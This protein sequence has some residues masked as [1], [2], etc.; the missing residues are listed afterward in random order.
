MCSWVGKSGA[1]ADL[2]FVCDGDAAPR[3]PCVNLGAFPSQVVIEVI[4]TIQRAYTFARSDNVGVFP[5]SSI[6]EVIA[7]DPATTFDDDSFL[8]DSRCIIPQAFSWSPDV[9]YRGAAKV[10]IIV[11]MG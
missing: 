7:T 2:C 10:P 1:T 6:V 9:D 11:K 4:A 3:A 8:V 5:F